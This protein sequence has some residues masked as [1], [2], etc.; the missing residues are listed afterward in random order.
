MALNIY[1]GPSKPTF[2]EVFV[3][4]NLGRSGQNL[5]FSWFWG[6]MVGTVTGITV[7]FHPENKWSDM[8]PYKTNGP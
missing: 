4:N 3:V 6:L 1:H 7:S 8:G 5:Y 2:L